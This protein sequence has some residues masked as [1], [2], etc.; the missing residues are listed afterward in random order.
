VT[1]SKPNI[2]AVLMD[3]KTHILLNSSHRQPSSTAA[4]IILSPSTTLQDMTMRL[5]QVKQSLYREDG[6]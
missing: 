5:Q 1:A 2:N 6:I 4:S 3:L